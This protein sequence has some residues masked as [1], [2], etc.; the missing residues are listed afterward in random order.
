MSWWS[1]LFIFILYVYISIT[2]FYLLLDNRETATTLSWLLVFIFFPF[3]G[4]IIYF[5]VGRGMRKKVGQA[6]VRQNLEKRM[7][8]IH[9]SIVDKQQADMGWIAEKYSLFEH[10]KLMRL[11]YHNSDS[12]LTRNTDIK[13]FFE[14]RDKFNVLL[15]DF[16][17]AVSHI[18]MEYFIWKSDAL[19]QRVVEVLKHK[20][21]Q[22]VDVRILYDS[23]GNYLSR[24]YL[25]KLR[26]MGIKIYAYYNFQSPLK[27]HTLNYRNHRKIV[28]ID[29][30]IGYIGGMNMGNEYIDGGERFASWR[31]TH[32]RIKGEAVTVLQEIFSVSWLNTTN[33]LID[34][35][36]VPIA[37][38]TG[39]HLLPVQ[40]TTSG[41]D[42]KW[43]SIKQLYFLL[44]SSAQK[45]IFIN[46]PYFIPDASIVMAL[47]TAAL[48]GIDVRIM[49]TG[50]L[51]KRLPYWAALTYVGELLN[52]G[53]QVYYYQKGF[54]H[55]KTIVVDGTSCSIGTA[56]MDMRSFELNYEINALIY[57]E[58]LAR[59]ME[60]RFQADMADARHFTL[61]D[62]AAIQRPQL[63]RNSLARLFAP[64]L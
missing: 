59:D 29:G 17:S 56:N 40:I 41:P 50:V 15:D 30:A 27:I 49:L 60:V 48:S 21:D 23:I 54:M 62:Y 38:D 11:L 42:S 44:I 4:I 37:N 51:D 34:I 55:A 6:L 2:I 47:K 22:G 24:R 28:V 26:R 43:E 36:P 25:K 9:Q 8:D 12:I 7:Q 35:R 61:E 53:V 39:D 31:D 5:L 20:I 16:S 3:G 19:S 18:H 63:L 64:L 10:K 32:M 58:S 45:T 52:A 1:S 14:G 13:I 46:T 57:D 33:E